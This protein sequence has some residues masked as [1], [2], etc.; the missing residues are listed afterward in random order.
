[1][2]T[3]SQ[4]VEVYKLHKLGAKPKEIFEKTGCH[5]YAVI[6]SIKQQLYTTGLKFKNY[7]KAIKQLRKEGL[8]DDVPVKVVSE[9]KVS[10][11]FYNPLTIVDPYQKLQLA[12][13]EVI[14]SAVT[15]K[16]GEIRKENEALKAELKK[17]NEIMEELKHANWFTALRKKLEGV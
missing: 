15:S 17:N 6:K 13:E 14:I 3:A 4:I 1:M 12:I 11:V 8:I 9:F 5:S 7:Q 16:V 10:P 2:L